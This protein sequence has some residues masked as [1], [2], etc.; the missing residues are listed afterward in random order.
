MNSK[1]GQ[2]ILPFHFFFLSLL[3]LFFIFL[4]VFSTIFVII[5]GKIENS[6]NVSKYHI[7]LNSQFGNY[8]KGFT[9]QAVEGVCLSFNI[10]PQNCKR[11]N[12]QFKQGSISY[13]YPQTINDSKRINDYISHLLETDGV[14]VIVMP[15]FTYTDFLVN[16]IDDYNDKNV[17]FIALGTIYEF[18]KKEKKW[19]IHLWE[20][21]FKEYLAGYYAGLYAGLYALK[22]S[23]VF[24]DYNSQKSGK[25]IAFGILGGLFILPIKYYA[26]GFR[27]G[28]EIMNKNKTKF[29]NTKTN[30][31]E[32]VVADYKTIGGF[33]FK[34]SLVAKQ[35]ALNM[36]KQGISVIFSIAVT[37]TKY[38]HNAAL[39]MNKNKNKKSHWVVG[40]DI[41]QGVSLY[42]DSA[43]K[44]DHK[45][46][47]SLLVSAVIKI[48]EVISHI[49]KSK[50]RK[51]VI[52][53][54]A[55]ILVDNQFMGIPERFIKTKLWQE[56]KQ[57]LSDS[58]QIL[59]ITKKRI[60]FLVLKMPEKELEQKIGNGKKTIW[61]EK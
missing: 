40:V 32:L 14:D 30:N 52:P 8:D 33:D 24:N 23:D 44:V 21:R 34:K 27:L 5:K 2:K 42:K 61:A 57:K 56:I 35:L 25:Q 43:Q 22:N 53:T 26:L 10:K 47:H 20:I 9:Q 50:I 48:K 6:S 60:E 46:D 55:E 37:L 19:P 59:P 49:I 3:G 16:F 13:G 58:M 54:K 17:E 45:A 1:F 18:L 15:G 36:Y 51:K 4:L 31:T 29:I 28:I 39:E 41:D 38:I 7:I 11:S 12:A